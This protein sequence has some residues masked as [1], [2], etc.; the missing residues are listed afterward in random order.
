MDDAQRVEVDSRILALTP[1]IVIVWGA[2]MLLADI[3]TSGSQ[4]ALSACRSLSDLEAAIESFPPDSRERIYLTTLRLTA[5]GLARGI[6]RRKCALGERHQAARD[7]KELFVRDFAKGQRFQTIALGGLKQLVICGFVFALA[8]ALALIPAV[9]HETQNLNLQYASLAFAMG[10]TLVG[11]FFKEWSVKRQI[12]RA[13]KHYDEAISEADKGYVREVMSEYRLAADTAE[14][15]WF[16]LTGV[17][18]RTTRAFESLLL[19][20]MSEGD[21]PEVTLTQTSV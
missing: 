15:A 10:V 21:S 2:N 13:F 7:R 5:A 17:H 20:V 1:N 16:L 6:E 4:T 3:S 8:R 14:Q 9:A 18:S 11:S 19:G 12:M